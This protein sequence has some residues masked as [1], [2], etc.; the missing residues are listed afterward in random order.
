M[1]TTSGVAAGLAATDPK[2]MPHVTMTATFYAGVGHL[3][4]RSDLSL[5]VRLF[6]R[7]YLL[8]DHRLVS[9]AYV[10][11]DFNFGG[12]DGSV[13]FELLS[14]GYELRSG[15]GVNRH[16]EMGELCSNC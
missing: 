13:L 9:H 4:A 16:I 6:F 10:F 3:L 7:A 8:L 2:L 14:Y 1:G 11:K 12:F 15:C 5:I